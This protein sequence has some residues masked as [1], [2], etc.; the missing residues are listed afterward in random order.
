MASV[1]S[2]GAIVRGDTRPG[3][4][5]AVLA[6]VGSA[7][8]DYASFLARY[9]DGARGLQAG[10][11]LGT[12]PG[13]VVQAYGGE[14]TLRGW[15]AAEFGYAGDDAGAPAELARQQAL[16]D[17][18]TNK[19]RR[20]LKSDFEQDS[21]V[22]LVNWLRKHHGYQGDEA[23]AGAAL[24]ALAPAELGIYARQLFFAELKE[25]GREYNDDGGPRF[26]S[27]LRGRRALPRC[28]PTSTPRARR[29]ATTAASRCTAARGCAAT[30][31]ATSSCSRR[32]A[33]RCW[34]WKAWR[35]RP[36]RAW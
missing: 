24:A 9:L 33:G 1:R 31:A 23:G 25:G 6:G 13:K 14:M 11:A 35:R 7:G 3:A 19:A 28:S 36:A 29:C 5:L 34:A 10:E 20:D 18:D 4:D 27:Y 22:Y 16:R 15:L 2:L 32:A 26:G 30:S 8:P 17:A 21:G 12:H